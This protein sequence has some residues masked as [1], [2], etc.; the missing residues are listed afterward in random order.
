MTT[1]NDI[2]LDQRKI[3]Y[4]NSEVVDQPL[5]SPIAE[6]G[7]ESIKFETQV[8]ITENG[9]QALDSFPMEDVSCAGFSLRG[10]S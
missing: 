1:N 2:F 6:Q 7:S 10:R 8:V 9:Y 5:K 3:A 4:L